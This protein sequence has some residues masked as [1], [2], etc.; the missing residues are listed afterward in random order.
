MLCGADAVESLRTYRAADIE[1]QW[2]AALFVDATIGL[3]A[4]PVL[5]LSESLARDE[6]RRALDEL[7]GL[8]ERLRR[9][10]GAL[11]A[12]LARLVTRHSAHDDCMT[13][14]HFSDEARA[15]ID[16]VVVAHG[17]SRPGRAIIRSSSA[18]RWMS[19][20]RPLP[21]PATGG[22]AGTGIGACVDLVLTADDQMSLATVQLEGMSLDETLRR[23]GLAD[24]R[25]SCATRCTAIELT[26]PTEWPSAPAT[27]AMSEQRQRP[28]LMSR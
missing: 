5:E 13:V 27:L 23:V 24:E 3:G 26:P 7:V 1:S 22:R 19:L 2:G 6:D 28:E 16:P 21:A 18:R 25:S 15:I 12:V 4:P 11:Y 9:P 17:S 14:L 8:V 10:D 20:R